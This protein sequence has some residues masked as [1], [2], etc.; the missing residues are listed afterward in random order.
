MGYQRVAERGEFANRHPERGELARRPFLVQSRRGGKAVGLPLRAGPIHKLQ[1]DASIRKRFLRGEQVMRSIL[2][3]GLV[4]GVV[5]FGA[6][7]NRAEQVRAA[8]LAEEAAKSARDAGESQIAH[9]VYFT[10][11]DNSAEAKKKMVEACKKYLT[12]HDGTVYF[13]AGIRGED[14]NRQINDREFD[15]ALHL[16]FKDK[17]SHDKYQDHERHKKFIEEN[18]D[19]WKKVRVFD[20]VVHK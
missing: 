20:A 18:K 11:K 12:E 9:M 8:R 10:L 3:C 7:W 19:N 5:L 16:V 1:R 6:L 2:A 4:L 14:F 15:V 17:A 13:S